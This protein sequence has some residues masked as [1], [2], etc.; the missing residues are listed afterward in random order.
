MAPTQRPRKKPT[1]KRAAPR[2]EYARADF[3][4]GL[5]GGKHAPV[6]PAGGAI[7]WLDPEIAAAFPTSRAVNKALAAIIKARGGQPSGQRKAAGPRRPG[8]SRR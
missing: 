2:P 1:A 5:K 4:A 8:S 6:A 7:V 3:P